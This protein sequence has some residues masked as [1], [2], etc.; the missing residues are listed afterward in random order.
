MATTRAYAL[1]FG[2]FLG[3]CVWKFGDPVILDHKI[4]EPT[5]LSD[6]LADA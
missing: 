4:G 2:L 5:T 6:F 3:V 1:V